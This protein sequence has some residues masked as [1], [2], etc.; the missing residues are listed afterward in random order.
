MS[1][2]LSVVNPCGFPLLPAFLSF[3]FGAEEEQLP[4]APTRVAQGLVVGTDEGDLTADDVMD[5]VRIQAARL[6]SAACRLPVTATR[7][8]LRFVAVTGGRTAGAG[9]GR[10][11]YP[12]M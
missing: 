9:G 1:G 5:F 12:P 7:A 10:P 3:Y 6:T 2:G 11:D 8:I 4:P